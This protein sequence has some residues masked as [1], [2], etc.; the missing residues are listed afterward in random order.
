M[1]YLLKASAVIAIFYILYKLF[2]QRE[3]F[4]QTNRGYLL[5]GLLVAVL[6]PLI[7]IP[8]YIE[9][10]PTIIETS[11]I[12]TITQ[13]P[14]AQSNAMAIDWLQLAGI[15]YAIGLI[16]FLGKLCIE[17]ASLKVLFNRHQFFKSG[18]YTFIETENE[19]PPFSFFNWI[20]YNPNNYSSEELEHILNHEKAHASELHSIDIILTQLAC[21]L[22]WFNP[23]IWLY[24][25]E[26]KQNLEFIADKKAQEFSNC[27]KSYQLILLKSSVPQHKFLITNNFYNSQIK[28]RIIMLHKSKSKKVNIWKYSLVLPIL[29]LFLMSFNTKEI[30]IEKEQPKEFADTPQKE[31]TD[32][33]NDLY[34]SL[35]SDETIDLKVENKSTEPENIAKASSTSITNTKPVTQPVSKADG[36]I[37]ITIIDKNTTDAELDKIKADLKKE[38]LTVKFKGVKRNKSGEITAIKIDAKSKNSNAN[39]NVNSENAIS[40]LKIVYDME[41]ESIS[42]GG[43]HAK[44][45]N[46]TYVYE[47]TDEGTFTIKKAGSGNNVVVMTEVHEDHDEDVEHEH[48]S[49]I[50]IR[51]NGKKGKVKTVRRAKN[52]EVISGDDNNVVEIIVEEENDN[53][54]EIVIVNGKRIDVDASEDVIIEGEKANVWISDDNDQNELITISNGKNKNNVYISGLNGKD[55]L[56]IVDGKEVKKD[57]FQSLDPKLIDSMTVLKDES[58]REKYGDKGKNGVIIIKLKK[59]KD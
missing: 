47:T 20:V 5:I 11:N 23:L 45:G 50:V 8:I 43:G 48:E 4:F 33:L 21:V 27:E 10:T 32:Q 49:K 46:N 29:A 9:Y 2:L 16:F 37:S 51:K 6:T 35:D 44:H 3:T 36:D 25:R 53:D 38:G 54:K 14:Q 12:Y 26:V 28:K 57:Y 1:E 34:N 42:I 59:K 41:N 56:F 52:V 17:L 22:M 15:I 55:P 24:K 7:V 19:I 58:A 31:A 40:P 18:S 30:F 39:Y 13:D